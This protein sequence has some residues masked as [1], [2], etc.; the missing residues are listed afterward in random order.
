MQ[1]PPLSRDAIV[2]IRN[3]LLLA[4]PLWTGIGWLAVHGARVIHRLGDHRAASLSAAAP[5]RCPPPRRA[6]PAP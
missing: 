6:R 1:K 5:P 4:V 2:G 3:G